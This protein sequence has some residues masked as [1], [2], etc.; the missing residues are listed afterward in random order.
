MPSNTRNLSDWCRWDFF[1]VYGMIIQ[2]V[3]FDCADRHF[4]VES[5]GICQFSAFMNCG[6][7][8]KF[9]SNIIMNMYELARMYKL[10]CDQ[11]DTTVYACMLFL[12]LYSWVIYT[13]IPS[14]A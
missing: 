9:V 2:M 8:Y 5:Y 1:L 7:M 3:F 11:F 14:T 6:Y 13:A 12:E 10:I 4:F